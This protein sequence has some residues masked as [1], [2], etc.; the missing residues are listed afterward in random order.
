MFCRWVDTSWCWASSGWA[1]SA[2]FSGISIG[3]PC[4]SHEG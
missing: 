4:A 2:P 1:P 3:A